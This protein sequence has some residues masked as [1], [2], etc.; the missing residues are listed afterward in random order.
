MSTDQ[1]RQHAATTSPPDTAPLRPGDPLYRALQLI[2]RA[3]TPTTPDE[4]TP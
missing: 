4:T 1:D 2:D 3:Y